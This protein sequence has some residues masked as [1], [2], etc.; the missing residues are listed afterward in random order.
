MLNYRANNNA[1]E[2]TNNSSDT[3]DFLPTERKK[4]PII[5]ITDSLYSFMR[6]KSMKPNNGHS[7]SRARGV[8]DAASRLPISSL[9]LIGFRYFSPQSCAHS[10]SIGQVSE[11]NCVSASPSLPLDPRRVVDFQS[12]AATSRLGDNYYWYKKI[13]INKNKKE[14]S[15]I[16]N[17]RKKTR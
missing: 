7:A 14:L 5:L 11:A 6:V 1:S 16:G 10:S 17:S 3:H 12:L 2:P 4:K 8:R 15:T 9:S 13:K